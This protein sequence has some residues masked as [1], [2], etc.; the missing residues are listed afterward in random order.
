LNQTNPANSLELLKQKKLKISEILDINQELVFDKE[1]KLRG[2]IREHFH[3]LGKIYKINSKLSLPQVIINDSLILSFNEF[4]LLNETRLIEKISAGITC[5]HIRFYDNKIVYSQTDEDGVCI[6]CYSM[7]KIKQTVVY[8]CNQRDYLD[9][10]N[11]EIFSFCEKNQITMKI[12]DYENMNN[13][14][15]CN[16]QEIY[17]PYLENKQNCLFIDDEHVPLESFYDALEKRF[18]KSST[19]QCKNCGSKISADSSLGLKKCF[20]CLL[21]VEKKEMLKDYNKGNYPGMNKRRMY[22]SSSYS[23]IEKLGLK[24]KNFNFDYEIGER[25]ERET[26]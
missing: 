5:D 17:K 26:F 20:E 6:Y 10:T 18:I 11:H 12:I 8:L 2:K 25:E 4:S 14:L 1:R 24:K 22:S 3:Q 13:N 19:L 21:G 15:N 9:E 23:F 16:Y 7:K